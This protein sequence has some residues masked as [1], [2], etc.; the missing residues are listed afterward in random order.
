MSSF[1]LP[2]LY[3]NVHYLNA[4]TIVGEAFSVIVCLFDN[5]FF[6]FFFFLWEASALYLGA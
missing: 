2:S 3:L 5:F 4:F 6:F 1:A